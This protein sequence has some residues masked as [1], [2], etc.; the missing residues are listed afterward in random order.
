MKTKLYIVCLSVFALALSG[1]SLLPSGANRRGSASSE[2][3]N[4]TSKSSNPVRPSS[5]SGNLSASSQSSVNRS[6]TSEPSNQEQS[7]ISE[8]TK[9]EWGDWEVIFE[10][11]CE[12]NG[13]KTR[14]CSVCGKVDYET[15]TP[16][17]HNFKAAKEIDDHVFIRTCSRC[18]YQEDVSDQY[19]YIYWEGFNLKPS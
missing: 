15:I 14:T 17:G 9:H 18:G 10:P 6:S 7:S 4:N 16:L 3:V 1:C 8:C 11:T 2:E 5:S 19:H 12:E 13:F